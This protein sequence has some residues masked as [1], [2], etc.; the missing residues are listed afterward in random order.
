MAKKD[1]HVKHMA[2]HISVK[3]AISNYGQLAEQAIRDELSKI[4]SYGTFEPILERDLTTSDYRSAIPCSMFLKEKTDQEGKFKSIKARLVAGGHMQDQ[5][6]YDNISAPTLS[7]LGLFSI[8]QV[9]AFQERSV[10]TADITS[11]YLNAYMP[12]STRIIMRID[13]TLT[14]L[15][16]QA[17][18]VYT[19]FKTRSGAVFVRLR[20]ALYGCLESAKLWNE[21]LTHTLQSY[22]F[23]SNPYDPCIL[24]MGTSEDRMTIGVYVDDLII[25]SKERGKTISLLTY[26]EGFF[27]PMARNESD[28]QSYLGI[29]LD[30]TIP[31]TISA[32]MP[33]YTSDVI[34]SWDVTGRCNTPATS[35]LFIT[36]TSTRLSTEQSK[37]FHTTVAQLLY[38]SKRTRP[39]ILVATTFLTTR[40][41]EPTEDDLNKLMRVL[42]Y[43]NGSCDLPL[44][45]TKRDFLDLDAYSDAS[46]AVHHDCKSHTGGVIRLGGSVIFTQSSKQTLNAKS[47]TEAE[48]IAL[49]DICAQLTWARLMLQFQGLIFGPSN[50]Y[51]DNQSVIT[52]IKNGR[53]TTKQSRHID[54]RFFH[55]HDLV[56]RKQISVVF[57]PTEGQ[58]ALVLVS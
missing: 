36:S 57:V 28:H 51:E 14:N 22:G 19:P 31:G 21:R 26:L 30:L 37:R 54:I 40:V 6:V 13:K 52:M 11:A 34:K 20:K 16:C 42:K 41:S 18:D 5:N 24:D 12:E 47:S 53:P 29:A 38:L 32:S 8:L 49:S 7:M 45:F 43:L 10:T 48:I 23:K 27:G 9:A 15:L 33:T 25:T 56:D 50:L 39:D 1:Y 2:L 55:A 46:Y 44:K 58:L 3:R 4:H 17:L 35:H